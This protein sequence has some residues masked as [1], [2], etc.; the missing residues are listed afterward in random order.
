MG[1]FAPSEQLFF[2]AKTSG[3]G[4]FPAGDCITSCA[5]TSRCPA[6][7]SM[8]SA[9]SQVSGGHFKIYGFNMADRFQEKKPIPRF[10]SFKFPQAP[11]PEADRP[12]ER[13]SREAARRDERSRHR[14]SRHR[15]RRDHPRSK[16]RRREH[17]EHRHSHSWDRRDHDE[18]V[19]SERSGAKPIMKEV[20]EDPD[21]FV[22]D[23]KGDRH[24]LAYGMLHRYSVP[25]YCRFG[26]GRVLGLPPRY[27]IDRDTVGENALVIRMIGGQEDSSKLKSKNILSGL[28]KEKGKLLRVRPQPIS[29]ATV[30]FAKDY[31]P[32][33]VSEKKYRGGLEDVDSDDEKY[34]YRSIHGR[35]KPEHYLPSDMEA[36]SETDSEDEGFRADLNEEIKQTNAELSR[37]TEANST[38]V[39]AWLQ[40]IDHQASLISGAEGVSHP[41]TYAE[42]TS[43]ADIRLSLYEKALKRVGPIPAKE[44]LLLGLLEEGAKLWDTKKLSEQWQT[45]LRSNS[46]FIGL[47]VKYLDFRQTQFMDFTYD[48]C[49]ATFVDCLKLNQSNPGGPEK[50]YVQ[51]YLFLRLTLF[52]REAGF[53]E[54]AVGLWQAILEL[55]FFPPEES[56]LQ[57]NQDELLSRFMQFWESEVARI[58]ELGAKGWKSGS[59]APIEPKSSSPTSSITPNSIFKSWTACERGRI[60]KARLPA[61]S[62]D[63]VEDDDPYRVVIF[64]DLQGILSKFW[65][66]NSAEVLID[67]FLFFCHLPPLA[68]PSNAQTTSR[69]AGDNFVRNELINNADSTL[70]DWFSKESNTRRFSAPISFPHPYFIHTLETLFSGQETWF[71]SL[72]SWVKATVNTQSVIDP[73]W[74][75]RTLRL[76]VE[77]SPSNDDLAEYALALEFAY[78]SKGAKKFAKSLLKQRSS[79]LR[80]YNAYALMEFRSGNL[81]AAEHVW[82]ATLSMSKTFADQDRV[83]N[84]ILWRTWI[85]ESLE[86]RDMARASHLLFALPQQSVDLKSLVE[87]S[88]QPTFSATNLLKIQSVSQLPG[89]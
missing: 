52:M 66:S 71:S 36:V 5:D 84:G 2:H 61:R 59:S 70:E 3:A 1:W 63:E 30:D 24:N 9:G 23:R 88:G 18:E 11:P 62:L 28:K 68:T 75:R 44:R 83:D 21:L 22:L 80:L 60:V 69:W 38:D 7:R 6:L 32:L 15:S 85:W 64:S 76:L 77:A 47:W 55:T 25:Y 14:S 57:N 81:S 89:I 40:L 4:V 67:S 56:N 79:S 29:D 51:C 74:V 42:K 41:L 49:L 8:D 26:R 87:A 17:R 13:H 27:K 45:T 35:A 37:K 65:E 50:V 86:F 43:L 20:E 16:E 34:A 73:D 19:A 31:L 48:R 58:G 54:N 72:Q 53:A 39:G 78:N 33:N 82:A 12:S 46:Q 10:T